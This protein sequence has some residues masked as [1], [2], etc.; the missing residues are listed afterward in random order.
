M[1]KVEVPQLMARY[2]KNKD[3]Q[4]VIKASR[5]EYLTQW[6]C[7]NGDCIAMGS[8]RKEW[9]S[10]CKQRHEFFLS[11]KKLSHENSGIMRRVRTAVK[12]LE[13]K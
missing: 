4:K 3:T 9:C 6:K 2:F 13:T 11:L 1:E 7:D 12:A 5:I 10:V 8:D